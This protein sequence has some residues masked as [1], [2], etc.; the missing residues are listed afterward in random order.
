MKSARSSSRATSAP[1]PSDIGLYCHDVDADTGKGT[2]TPL[3]TGSLVAPTCDAGLTCF[4]VLAIPLCVAECDPLLLGCPAGQ[5]CNYRT[6]AFGCWPIMDE[7]KQELEVCEDLNQCEPGS[8]CLGSEYAAACD[9]S[10][11]GCCAAYC[12][13]DDPGVCPSVGEIC[14][15]FFLPGDAPPEYQDVGVCALPE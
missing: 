12:D 4:D 10:E 13:L 8:M 3:C 14:R 5:A 2:C 1:I 11:I 9:P 7:P 15:P 6:Y